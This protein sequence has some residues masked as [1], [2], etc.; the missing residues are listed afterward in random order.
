MK[1]QTFETTVAG[2]KLIATF[3]NL[4]EQTNGSVI[5][6][7][8]ET[9]LLVTAVMNEHQTLSPH[10]SLSVE[11]SEK[12]RTADTTPSEE[13][14]LSACIIDRALRPLFDATMRH[15][16]QVVVTVLVTG[17]EDLDVLGVL[18]ASLALVVSD[19]PWNGPIG[20]V[21]IAKE[22]ASGR[23]I[24]NP[25][26][27]ERYAPK[28]EFEV[29]ACG[30]VGNINLIDV[31]ATESSEAELVDVF[32]ASTVIHEALERF[33]RD[34][35]AA[36]GKTKKTF[37]LP[38]TPAALK[39][40]FAEHW[41]RKLSQTLF[42]NQTGVAHLYGLRVDF[43]GGAAVAL[44][45]DFDKH[46][47]N[48]HFNDALSTALNQGVINKHLRPDGRALDEIQPLF[49]Q[50][51]GISPKLHGS[52]IFYLGGTHTLSELTLSE[53]PTTFSEVVSKDGE[54]EQLFKYQCYFPPFSIGKTKRTPN[55]N[56]R[57]IGHQAFAKKA[58]QAVIPDQKIFPYTIKLNSKIL[59]SNG[60]S[61]MG[62]VCAS[63]LALQDGGVPIT[64]P[65]A[66]INIGRLK[67]HDKYVLLTDPQGPEGEYSDMDCTVAG[68][69]VGVTAIEMTMKME[70]VS[71]VT[72]AAALEKARL[73]R[74][75]ILEIIQAEIAAPRKNILPRAQGHHY[76]NRSTS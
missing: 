47:A 62:S 30:N 1:K 69:R 70:G 48:T 52:G 45:V 24:I 35:V 6:Q 44:G 21:R 7:H 9:M 67:Q 58:M 60:S 17:E 66:D 57:L 59:A 10:F 15:E 51:G 18:G 12:F 29:L 8:G 31:T 64:R 23:I 32:A 34:I 49:A 72:L 68:T 41:E 71:V 76:G 26:D 5:L 4:T 65:V 61:V 14:V 54:T 56:Q 53:S 55:S 13:A 75:H 19:I 27:S 42:S 22:K 25:T 50:A 63:S 11:F 40:Y 16:I 39:V 28:L 3:S 20:A 37:A 43:L 38:K 33:Q 2:R 74:L 46:H 73:A 36:V